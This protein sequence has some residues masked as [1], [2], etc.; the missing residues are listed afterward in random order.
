MKKL[1][2]AIL[3]ITLALFISCDEKK[4]EDDITKAITKITDKAADVVDAVDKAKPKPQGSGTPTNSEDEDAGGETESETAEDTPPPLTKPALSSYRVRTGQVATFPKVEGHSYELKQA[5]S[6]VTLEVSDENTGE[7]RATEAAT[8]VV[9]VA[10]FDGNTEDSDPIEFVDVTLTKPAISAYT[11]KVGEVAT[12]SKVLGHSYELK[13]AVNGVS[14]HVSSG[15]KGRVTSTQAASGVVV[16]A[17]LDD[18]SEES[19]PIN[20]IELT[21]PVLNSYRVRVGQA[22]TFT[23]VEGHTYELKEEKTG[24]ALTEVTG[25]RMQVTATQAASDVIIVATLDDNTEE[26]NPIEFFLFYVAN[27]KALQAEIKRAIQAHGNNA[28]L[29]YIDTSDITDMSELFKD[30]TTFNGDISKWNTSKVTD[31]REMFR[32]ATSFNQ[33]LNNWDVSKVI[34][35]YRM[36]LH[37]TSFN[38]PLNNW[39]VSSVGDMESMFQGAT[40]FNQNISGWKE[41]TDDE[42]DRHTNNMFYHAIAMQEAYKPNLSGWVK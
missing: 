24:V 3:I 5:V 40:S 12:F 36:F 17:T 39:D 34:D 32:G 20:F 33:P 27:K 19:D 31:M 42:N 29:N 15:N 23:K 1:Y 28:N 18:S 8:G 14:L 10:T 22:A 41:W 26:S 4:A 2:T 30:D 25:N 7:V 6:G 11:L 35:M 16:V 37:A 13:Q 9:I 38:Q 21:K